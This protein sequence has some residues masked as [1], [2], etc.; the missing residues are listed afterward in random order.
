M[1]II[2]VLLQLLLVVVVVVGVLLFLPFEI[3]WNEKNNLRKWRFFS[4]S[5]S[6]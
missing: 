4:S 6:F 5:S 3:K 2:S 1:Y